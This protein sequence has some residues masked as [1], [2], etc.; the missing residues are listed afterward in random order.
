[1][2][3]SLTADRNETPDAAAGRLER[4]L[5]HAAHVDADRG[6][7]AWPQSAPQSLVEVPLYVNARGLTTSAIP[8]EDQVF[9]IRF[10]FISDELE[11][12]TSWAHGGHCRCSRRPWRFLPRVLRQRELDIHVDIWPMPVEV[13][14]PSVSTR[15]ARTLR[16][17]PSRSIASGA[18][19]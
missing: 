19:W 12:F 18:Y 10:D 11:I 8:Y 15:I 4:H 1:M 3:R 5:R 13:R 7:G 17:T 16:M 6:Q 14:T 2:I 9:E